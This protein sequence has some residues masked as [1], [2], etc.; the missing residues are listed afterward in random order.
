M[1]EI[2]FAEE[3]RADIHLQ[4]G[5]CGPEASRVGQNSLGEF[6]AMRG[7]HPG[8]AQL[9]SCDLVQTIAKRSVY[10]AAQVFW[11]GAAFYVL[12]VIGQTKVVIGQL[13]CEAAVVRNVFAFEE[14]VVE[15]SSGCT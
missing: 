4:V 5:P 14:G 1:G 9:D 7:P 6:H 13:G 2:L 15:T 3:I 8:S 10:F 12:L 11:E